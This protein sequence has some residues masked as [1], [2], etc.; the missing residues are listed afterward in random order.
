MGCACGPSPLC[1]P[2][3]LRAVIDGALK[4]TLKFVGRVGGARNWIVEEGC[5]QFPLWLQG[6]R[7]VRGTPIGILQ[8]PHPSLV[9]RAV[10]RSARL[11]KTLP[12]FRRNR[13]WNVDMCSIQIAALISQMLLWTCGAQSQQVFRTQPRNHTVRMGAT[14]VLRCEVLRA[15]GTVQWV[16]DGLLLGPERSLPGFPRYSMIVN[17]R[18]GQYHLQIENAQLEDDATF[19][20]QAGRSESSEPIVSNL[21]WLDVQIPPAEPHFEPD[22]PQHWEAGRKYSV[23]C[24]AP[25][26]KPEAEITLYKDGVEL[27]GAQSFTT[28]GSEDKLLNTHTQVTFTA[29]SSDNGRQLVCQAK[30]SAH[31]SPVQ[32]AMTMTVYCTWGG[33]RFVGAPMVVGRGSGGCQ[34]RDGEIVLKTW[35]EDPVARTSRSALSLRIR[36]D[37]NQA[38]LS[39]ESANLASAAPLITS[40]TLTVIFDPAEVILLGSL[41]AIENQELNVNCFAK[42]SNPPVQMRWWLGNTEL[43]STAVV[44]EEGKNGGMTTLSNL[45]YRVSKQDNGLKLSCVAFNKGTKVSKTQH[46][47]ITV[48]SPPQKVWIDGPSPDIPLHA[49]TK[50]RLVCFSTGGSPPGSLFWYKNGR[51]VSNPLKSTLYDKGVIRELSVVLSASDNMAEY[52]CEATNE[53]QMTISA[54]TRLQVLF[55]SISMK[56]TAQSDQFSRGQTFT[57][58]CLSGSSN[59][60]S[61]ISW[62]LGTHRFQGVDRPQRKAEYG[63]FAV[64]SLLSLNASSQLHNKR[65]ICQSHSAVLPEGAKTFFQLHVLYPPEFSPEQPTRIQ[66]VEDEMATIPL[67]V[68]ANPEE[69]SCVWQ[70][71]R[72]RLVR[73]RN[74]RFYRPNEFTLEIQNVTRKDAGTYKIKCTNEEGVSHTT[75]LLDVQYAPSVK[76][77]R[78]P[79]YVNLGDTADLI[80]V[81][82]ANPIISEMF[83]WKWLGEEEVEMGE[84]IQQDESGLLTIHGVTRAHAGLYQCSADNGIA[85]PGSADVQLIVQFG[86]ELQKGPQWTKVASRGDGTSTA[87]L[88]CRAEGIP[89]VD[90]IWEKNHMLMDFKNPRYEQRIVREGSFHTSSVHVVNVSA[91]LDYAIFSCTARNALGDDR[92]DIQLVSTNHPD[93]P[94][95]L[96]LLS[97]SH[98]AVTLDWIPG[99]DGGLPQKFRVRYQWDGSSSF[100]YVDVVPTGEA[101]FTVTGLLPATTYNFSVNAINAI[102]ESGY[103]DNDAVLTVTT[104]DFTEMGAP[105]EEEAHTSGALSTYLT[106]VFTVVF[107]V[108][109]LVNSL[110]CF[111]GLKRRKQQGHA[112]GVEGSVP[113]GAA[114]EEE[115][116]VQS[117]ASNKYESSE[118]INK[119]AQRTLLVDSGSETDSNLYESCA[120]EKPHYYYPT[121]DYRPPVHTLPEEVHRPDTHSHLYEEV[122][123]FYQDLPSSPL[124][125]PPLPPP[126]PLDRRLPHQRH[127]LK[128]SGLPPPKTLR[129]APEYSQLPFELRGELV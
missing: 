49:G 104:L 33:C 86:P 48:Y 126:P 35:E 115:G 53:A 103:A 63:G 76:A 71:H 6:L 15:S 123:G 74:V 26:A 84:E 61:N 31:P 52:R 9:F 124:P 110:G 59:P 46:A 4:K 102:G 44:V 125:Q 50:V 119:A 43:N 99:F 73:E 39:C 82:D 18:R 2:S 81:A 41:E 64:S 77:E 1:L 75:V 96:R 108:L 121:V 14:A 90:F 22:W 45:T 54:Q 109:L 70:H 128:A 122:R 28:A 113:N 34:G 25:D 101:S 12:S 62:I 118:K 21:A 7:G 95:Y 57:L 100:R 105:A 114:K 83:S 91:L 107:G 106:V 60:Q 98:N 19:N 55:P 16:K 97:A 29:V 79:V 120:V 94:S 24:V 72:E 80:C 67:L 66:V 3:A 8:Q 89:Q 51:P 38:V 40:R 129:Q 17:P 111:F 47:E 92:L 13:G 116:S 10:C 117:T 93:A 112:G 30:N 78:D 11:K 87:E 65:I 68:S 37:D 20:C 5:Q 88:V 56:I 36:P 23:T 42:S 58:Q 127:A 69:V 85:P 27:T 32:T